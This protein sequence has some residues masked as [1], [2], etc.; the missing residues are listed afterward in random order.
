MNKGRFIGYMMYA[1]GIISS[2]TACQVNN[3]F[4]ALCGIAGVLLGSILLSLRED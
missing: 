3:W 2:I 1:S 4:V